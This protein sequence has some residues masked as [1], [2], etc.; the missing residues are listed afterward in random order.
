MAGQP[1][2]LPEETNVPRKQPLS[3]EIRPK[4]TNREKILSDLQHLNV[5][6]LIAYLPSPVSLLYM[7]VK[8]I[9]L[10]EYQNF[11]LSGSHLRLIQIFF[12]TFLGL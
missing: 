9:G 5:S 10:V 8:P 3:T 7:D 2:S 12:L 4:T 6:N 11:Y 1:E